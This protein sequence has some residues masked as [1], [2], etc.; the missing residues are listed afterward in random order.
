M[1]IIKQEHID[2]IKEN[3]PKYGSKHCEIHLNLGRG[4]VDYIARKKLKLGKLDKSVYGKI[5]SDRKSEFYKKS[6]TYSVNHEPFINIKSK[7]VSYIL[8]LLWADGNVHEFKNRNKKKVELNLIT[9][10][11][12]DIIDVFKTTGHWGRVDRKRIGKKPATCLTTY[13]PHLANYLISNGYKSK[14]YQS[15]CEIIKNIPN[16]LKHYWFRGLFD[17]DG[18]LYVDKKERVNINISSSYDQDWTYIE[19][20]L[21]DLKI[22]FCIIKTIA[23]TGNKHSCVTI[24]NKEGCKI[25]LDY[26]YNGYNMDNIGLIRKYQKYKTTRFTK[27]IKL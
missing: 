6:H 16:E 14:S 23:K 25:F 3:F 26:I 17:G 27:K 1:N 10:D 22:N 12:N 15:A 9:D 7:E 11:I 8:G 24:R 20:L 18:C 21:N 13:N 2:Y 4:K 19:D 5:I